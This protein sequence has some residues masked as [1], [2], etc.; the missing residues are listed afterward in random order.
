MQT[1]AHRRSFI[2]SAAV[3]GGVR[4]LSPLTSR[5]LKLALLSAGCIAALPSS[6]TSQNE[7]SK[8]EEVFVTAS[9]TLT[10]TKTDAALTEIPQSVSVVT[11]EDFQDRAAIDFQDI[12]RYSAGVQT[13]LSGLD[14][15]SDYFA[16]RGFSTVQY[17]D[18][19]NRMPAYIYGARMENFTLERA[20]VLRGPSSTLYGAGGVGGLLNGVSKRPQE[21]FGA[22]FG[23]VFGTH[24]RKELQV[25]VTGPLTDSI[26]AR[27]VSVVR[28]GQLI[29]ES[30]ADDRLVAMP[31]ITFRPSID[32]EI[33]LIGLY[34]KDRQGTQT[35]VP[36]SK[37]VAAV[38]AEDRISPRAFLGEPN[39]NKMESEYK[40]GTMLVSHDFGNVA[41]INSRTR[42]FEVDADYAEVYGSSLL[43]YADP[44]T[45]RRINRSYF[46]LRG[47]YDGWSTDNNLILK[48]DTGPLEHQLLFGVDYTYF[49]EDR[50]EG[51]PAATPLDLYNPVYGVGI[52]MPPFTNIYQTKNTN[53]GFYAQEQVRAWDRLSFV[54]GIRRDKVTS[55]TIRG[56]TTTKLPDNTAT[57][58]RVGVIFD[59]IEGVSP[60]FNYSESFLPVFGTNFAGTP[61]KARPGRQYEAGVKLE[62]SLGSLITLSVFD[63]KEKN[64]ISR[65][66]DNVQNMI[67]GGSVGSKGAELEANL[68]MPGDVTLTASYSYT[69]A[70]WLRDP[71][72][73]GVPSKEGQRLDNLPEHQASVWIAKGFQLTNAIDM[74]IGG[75]VR[76]MGDKVDQFD[77]FVMPA[78][79]LAD[80]MIEFVY[81]Q[82]QFGV[83]ASN[84]FDTTV[85]TRCS[86]N[87]ALD[88]GFCFLSRDRSILASLRR[89]F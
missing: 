14:M 47:L 35:Y 24:D 86:K 19:L 40:S 65:D 72:P 85:Y 6:A 52:S 73:P 13:E 27:L 71:V 41:T 58:F 21:A 59:V 66:P 37:T 50:S 9:R 36:I 78:V 67:Q 89:K 25:D 55:K 46:V 3:T 28:D 45:R 48:F 43:G 4:S 23:M 63:I 76:Y 83:N 60:Y 26:S 32:T 8:L 68:R 12:F 2:L 33:T 39:F 22:D 15:R 38:N 44:D 77:N 82:W 88:E 49:H 7:E 87:P 10:G 20:E 54:A 31:A 79:T 74:S 53:L 70:K 62:P 80:A 84:I 11:A 16:A 75:G 18:G 81:D 57:T 51:F 64:Y 61:Y 34:Q 30:Q 17:L 56:G 29:H 1:P 42:Y 69:R 5:G